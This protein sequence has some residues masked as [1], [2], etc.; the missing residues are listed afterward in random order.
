MSMWQYVGVSFWGNLL[1]AWMSWEPKESNQFGGPNPY[2]DTNKSCTKPM[3][4]MLVGCPLKPTNE[5]VS[6]HTGTELHSMET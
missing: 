6:A 1:V 4:V 5:Q 2:F 3:L